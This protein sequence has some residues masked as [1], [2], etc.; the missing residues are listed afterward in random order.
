M[1]KSS[2]HYLPS[3]K[4]YKG[5]IHKMDGQ[6]HTGVKHSASSKV[7]KHSKPKKK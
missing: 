4:E 1:A 2:K 3:G 5:A 6:L 7:V